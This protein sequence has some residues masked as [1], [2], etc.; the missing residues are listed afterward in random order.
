MF[1]FLNN[2]TSQYSRVCQAE[3]PL[4]PPNFPLFLL[5]SYDLSLNNDCATSQGLDIEQPVGQPVIHQPEYSA[6]YPSHNGREG[7]YYAPK[8]LG[9]RLKDIDWKF[10]FTAQHYGTIIW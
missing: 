6:S 9:W 5:A 8:S 10:V 7:L 1:Y 2:F 4:L 3:R